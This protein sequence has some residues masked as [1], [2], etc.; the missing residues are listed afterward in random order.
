M[1][2]R[3]DQPVTRNDAVRRVQFVEIEDRLIDL[4]PIPTVERTRSPPAAKLDQAPAGG[5]T[6]RAVEI[7]NRH[8]LYV[9]K[10]QTLHPEPEGR[11]GHQ[12]EPR[13]ERGTQNGREQMCRREPLARQR[14]TEK[15]IG[16]HSI[17]PGHGAD[18]TTSGLQELPDKQQRCPIGVATPWPLGPVALKQVQAVRH[19]ECLYVR[20]GQQR[21]TVKKA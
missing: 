16:E 15:R 5:R 1:P 14:R 4:T 3:P 9:P 13:R 19:D 21:K 10:Q 7:G 2:S 17:A 6:A 8:V 20:L 18:R 12:E 11:T